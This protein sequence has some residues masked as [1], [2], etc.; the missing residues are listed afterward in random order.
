MY[1]YAHMITYADNL[2][3]IIRDWKANSIIDPITAIESHWR[4]Q[5]DAEC[6]E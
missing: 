4:S 5:V 2:L 3:T 1:D 6:G